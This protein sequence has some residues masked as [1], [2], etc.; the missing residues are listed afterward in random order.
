MEEQRGLRIVALPS[1]VLVCTG[2]QPSVA[3]GALHNEACEYTL[4]VHLQTA[5]GTR[6]RA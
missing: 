6:I 3:C 2:L 1:D 5:G 4:L